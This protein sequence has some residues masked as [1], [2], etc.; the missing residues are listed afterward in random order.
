MRILI[1]LIWKGE[2]FRGHPV[3]LLHTAI[4]YTKKKNPK[5]KSPTLSFV[6][7]FILMPYKYVRQS[8]EDYLY[9]QVFIQICWKSAWMNVC[10]HEPLLRLLFP[11]YSINA[12]YLMIHHVVILLSGCLSCRFAVSFHCSHQNL[13]WKYSWLILYVWRVVLSFSV[14]FFVGFFFFWGW[15]SCLNWC[16]RR[17]EGKWVCRYCWGKSAVVNQTTVNMLGLVTSR[18][19]IGPLIQL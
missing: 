12:A 10:L 15:K 7:V 14:I 13:S 18:M 4:Q 17:K 3:L 16:L 9:E 5:N 19:V 11:Q 2:V 6:L 1:L 8:L